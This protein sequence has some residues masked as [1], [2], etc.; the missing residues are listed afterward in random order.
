MR[1]IAQFGEYG[2]QIR[3][4]RQQGMGDGSIKV[5]QEPIYAKF[6]PFAE[7]PAFEIELEKAKEIFGFKGRYQHVD[8][9]TPVE[10]TY[11]ISVLDTRKQGWDDEVRQIVEAELVRK[12]GI[13]TD[14]FIAEATPIAEPFANWDEWEKPVH[15]LVSMLVDMGYDL[16]LALDYERLFGPDR[17]QVIEA[18][19]A[20]LAAAPVPME[21]TVSA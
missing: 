21:E 7:E 2:I 8:E 18:L 5:T 20:C 14:F 17:P 6:K 11:R 16:Q 12:A 3:P 19:E 1:A 4:Q 13:N 9:A 10:I 15:Q